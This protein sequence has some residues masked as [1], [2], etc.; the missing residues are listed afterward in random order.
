MIFL[1]TYKLEKSDDI[2]SGIE[3]GVEIMNNTA[4]ENKKNA[5]HRSLLTFSSQSSLDKN[6]V[7]K[8]CRLKSA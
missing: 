4:S 7:E 2:S 1:L 6:N 5:D 8:L 3:N